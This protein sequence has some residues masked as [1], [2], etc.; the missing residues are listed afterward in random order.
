MGGVIFAPGPTWPGPPLYM[1]VVLFAS[2]LGFYSSSERR[3]LDSYK[4]DS[5]VLT[6]Y[7][8]ASFSRPL[9]LALL[10]SVHPKDHQLAIVSY[11]PSSHVSKDMEFPS[12]RGAFI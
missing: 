9:S 8:L 11:P 12:H 3:T 6:T 4:G 10:A 1:L 5:G 2:H 7:H